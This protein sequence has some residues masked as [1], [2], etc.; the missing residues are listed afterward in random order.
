MPDNEPETI[1]G[2]LYGMTARQIA[3]VEA[4]TFG[5]D[6]GK[7]ARSAV[8]AGYSAKTAHVAANVL[9]KNLKVRRAIEWI[10]AERRASN[11]LKAEKVI[12][13]LF[14]IAN[15]DIRDI[16]HF[17]SI[18]TEVPQSETQGRD[19]DGDNGE[20]IETEHGPVVRQVHTEVVI[21]DWDQ[22]TAE[23]AAAIASVEQGPNGIKVKMH[24]KIPALQE[25]GK[26][27]GIADTIKLVGANGGPIETVDKTM[28]PKLAMQIY[29]A[30]MKGK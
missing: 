23:Q 4:Y 28:D 2:N 26:Y 3:F 27:L 10:L 12:A 30:E 9:L 7:K 29:L 1:A 8:R 22:L 6:A 5:P 19:F 11:E 25:L 15:T 13:R 14:A 24:P 20:V 16:M 18:V 17:R 21:T